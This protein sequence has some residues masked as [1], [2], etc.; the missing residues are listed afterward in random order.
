[1]RIPGIAELPKR[2]KFFGT[3]GLYLPRVFYCHNQVQ[4]GKKEKCRKSCSECSAALRLTFA[5]EMWV[6]VVIGDS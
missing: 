6:P 2:R 5:R 4:D 3:R 1:M